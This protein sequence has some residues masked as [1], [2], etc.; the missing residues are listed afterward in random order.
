MKTVTFSLDLHTHRFI[1]LAMKVEN[2]KLDFDVA[3]DLLQFEDN[4]HASA[5]T[6]NG[7]EYAKEI[8]FY[9]VY[10]SEVI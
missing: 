10:D 2:N 7:Q 5:Y 8:L 9:A 6:K 3:C 1:E 4:P